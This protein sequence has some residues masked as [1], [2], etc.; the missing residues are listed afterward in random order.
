MATTKEQQQFIERVG[1]LAAADMRASGVLASLTIAQAI[2][3]SGWGTSE[4]ATKANA[5]FGIKADGRWPGRVYSKETKECYDGATYT[6]VTALFR[7]YGSWEESV[8]DH[9]DFLVGSRRYAAVI[10]ETNY[11]KAAEA[12]KAAGYATAP[13]YAEKLVRLIETY[14]LTTYDG[15]G[16]EENTL[17]IRKILLTE[18][19]CYKAGQYITVKGIMVHSTGAN[20]PTL[21]RY[22]GP[23]DGIIGQNRYNNHWNQDKPDGRKVCVHGF[24]GED[25]NG[26]IRVYQTLPW[27]M[28]GWHAGGSANGTHIGFEICEDGLE[29]RS[30]FEEVYEKAVQLCAHLCKEFNLDP[31]KDGVLICHSEGCARGIASNHGDVMHWLPRHGRT[32]ND[33]RRAVKSALSD[34][35]AVGG[36]TIPSTPETPPTGPTGGTEATFSI[37]DVVRFK[38]GAHYKSANATISAGAPAAGSAKV[39]AYAAGAKHPYHVIHTDTT[40]TVYGWVGAASL[41]AI[42]VGGEFKVG[43]IVRFS[44]G[45]HYKSSMAAAASG[46]PKAGPAKVTAVAKKAKHP[47]HI[48]HTDGTST[49]HGWV[50]ANKVSAGSAAA[51]RTYTVSSGDSLWAIAA[52][53]LGNGSRYTEIKSLNGLTTNTIYAGQILKLPA[54]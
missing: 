31:A 52:K 7:A 2:L 41:E 34:A 8:N 50:D 20:N 4:L 51:G 3:E 38:G 49:V 14:G 54:A 44:G 27:N 12:I 47:Y 1:A 22:I 26:V 10:G 18:N 24:I 17:E 21:R 15:A 48:V 53:Q 39:T 5:L 30:Y 13:D 46:S 29:D 33:F 25:K 45:S 35:G 32:M 43:D 28:L 11:R 36:E 40:S 9:S 37:G 23:D 42:T 19:A 6:T 16:K